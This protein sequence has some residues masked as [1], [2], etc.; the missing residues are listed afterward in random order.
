M[1]NRKVVLVVEDDRDIATLVAL[2][3]DSTRYEIIS[4]ERI[5]DAHSR[6]A[7]GPLLDCVILDVGLPDGCGLWLCE[8]IKAIYPALPVVVLTAGSADVRQKAQAAGA[9][10]FIAKPF[11]P[12]ALCAEIERLLGDG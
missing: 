6:L 4:V 9:D 3:F 5:V 10:V 8:E 2:C 11:E 12:D 7:A 1:P